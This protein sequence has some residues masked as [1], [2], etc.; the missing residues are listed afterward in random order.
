MSCKWIFTVKD[1]TYGTLDGYKVRLMAKGYTQTCV[2]D[3]H[4]TFAPMTK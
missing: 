2:I 3:Y 1:R 4:E